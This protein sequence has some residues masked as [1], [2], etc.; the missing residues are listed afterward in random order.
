MLEIELNVPVYPTEECEKV[1]KAVN[2][3]FPD[4]RL[5]ISTDAIRGTVQSLDRFATLLREQGIRN[6]ARTTLLSGLDGNR[7]CFALNKQAAYAGK[8]SFAVRAPLGNINVTVSTDDGTALIDS[9][10]PRIQ[11]DGPRCF[12]D[13][14]NECEKALE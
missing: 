7:L 3:I 14:E 2:N 5:D 13:A 12:E 4:A 10:A 6:A 9:L 1:A 8:V 11:K